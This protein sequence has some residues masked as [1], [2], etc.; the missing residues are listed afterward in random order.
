MH[1]WI[2]RWKGTSCSHCVWRLRS[3]IYNTPRTSCL[4][5]A[6]CAWSKQW[7]SLMLISIFCPISNILQNQISSVTL[8]KVECEELQRLRKMGPQSKSANL[9]LGEHLPNGRSQNGSIIIK[10]SPNEV[11]ASTHKRKETEIIFPSYHDNWGLELFCKSPSTGSSH[12]DS[13]LCIGPLLCIGPVCATLWNNRIFSFFWQDCMLHIIISR[14]LALF[15][16]QRTSWVLSLPRIHV[17]R[18]LNS[19]CM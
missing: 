12:S 18:T 8:F 15:H 1:G 2:V 3:A 5:E 11:L 4:L 10:V 7:R 9:P 17:Q 6:P 16:L 13:P 19:C 14:S